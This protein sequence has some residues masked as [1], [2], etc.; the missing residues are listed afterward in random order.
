MH[1]A[2]K[3]IL[4]KQWNQKYYADFHDQLEKEIALENN[5]FTREIEEYTSFMKGKNLQ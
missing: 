5:L 2:K 3:E 4:L 1:Q